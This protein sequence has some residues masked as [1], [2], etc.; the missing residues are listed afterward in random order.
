MKKHSWVIIALVIAILV[1]IVGIVFGTMN[2]NPGDETTDTKTTTTTSSSTTSS[3]STT[4][5]IGGGAGNTGDPDDDGGSGGAGEDDGSGDGGD[6]EHTHVEEVVPA[7]EATCESVGLTEGKK[8]SVCGTTLVAQQEI[9]KLSHTYDD[10]YDEQCNECGHTRDVGCEH[11]ETEVIPGYDATCTEPGL[12]DGTKCKKCGETLVEQELTSV[13]GHDEEIEYGYE[14]TCKKEGL[15]DK[16]YCT[17]CDTVFE[18]HEPIPVIDCRPGDWI[19]DK[20]A[21]Y[22][23][24]GHKYKKCTMCGETLVEEDIPVVVPVYSEGLEFT[25]YYEY[26]YQVS[27]GTCTERNIVIPSF[28]NGKYVV[29]IAEEGF[30]DSNITSVEIPESIKIIRRS[31]FEN[32][33]SLTSIILPES[34]TYIDNYA[35]SGCIKL[36]EIYV[37]DSVTWIGPNAFAFCFELTEFKIPTSQ[38]KIW[39]DTFYYCTNLKK[40]TIHADVTHLYSWMFERCEALE[41][42]KYEGTKE[43]W[44]EIWK[45][46]N[47]WNG[48]NRTFI[49]QC[50]N[51]TINIFE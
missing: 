31:A 21:S 16:R 12:T 41:V 15:S 35:F 4:T 9:P 5:T 3:S 39:Q 32:C 30:K 51:G 42:I 7:V 17:K 1:L 22:T 37:P 49:I 10:D 18:D 25:E 6:T 48:A 47:W 29:A 8:C 34:T 28:Y 36:A 2:I 38:T 13:G 45:D 24:E 26:G 27:I 20:E 14:P 11:A 44:N 19:V 33:E 23:E 43:Q 50:T 40:V 46:T